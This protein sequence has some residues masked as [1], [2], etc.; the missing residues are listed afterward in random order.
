[1]HRGTEA[2][3]VVI[4]N[5]SFVGINVTGDSVSISDCEVINSGSIGVFVG[6]AKDVRINRCNIV[7]NAANAAISERFG[8]YNTD[9]AHVVDAR[10]NWWGSSSGPNTPG[11]E[12]TRGP[13]DVSGFATEPFRITIPLPAIQPRRN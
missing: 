1:M 11:A 7:G 6:A 8:L 12:Q 4:R 9:A 3:G 2:K 10:A 5:S 13:V